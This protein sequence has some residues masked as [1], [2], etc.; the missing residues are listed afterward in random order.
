MKNEQCQHKQSCELAVKRGA[1]VSWSMCDV[2]PAKS[3]AAQPTTEAPRRNT[4]NFLNKR[5]VK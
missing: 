3:G 2:C 5:I 1:S 4:P